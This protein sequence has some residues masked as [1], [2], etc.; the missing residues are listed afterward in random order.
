MR[1]HAGAVIGSISASAPAFRAQVPV[2]EKLS[3]AVV[4]AADEL[5]AQI[6]GG[7]AEVADDLPSKP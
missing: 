4:A 6:G 5:S 1:D 3:R 7:S 2:I